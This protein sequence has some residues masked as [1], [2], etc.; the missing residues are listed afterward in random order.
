MSF[1]ITVFCFSHVR[2]ALGEK[3]VTLELN[4]GA[5][6][7]DVE[8]IV[9]EMASGKLEGMLFRIAVNRTYVSETTALEEGDELALIPP[10]QGG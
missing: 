10:V 6:T 4:D 9:R 7:A 8:K 3:T 5:N 1:N 2:E